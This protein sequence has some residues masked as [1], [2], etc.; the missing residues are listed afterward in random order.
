MNATIRPVG[1]SHDYRTN[2]WEA[3]CECGKF[4]RPPTTMYATQEIECPKCGR[5]YVARYNDTPP[6]IMP[7]ALPDCTPSAPVSRPDAESDTAIK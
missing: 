1:L 4:W 5:R 7:V 6:V 3:K 2:C